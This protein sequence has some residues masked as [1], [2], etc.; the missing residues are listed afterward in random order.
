MARAIGADAF[1]WSH[2]IFFR[3]GAYRPDTR[4]GLALLAHE[5]THTLQQPAVAA[6][7]P[8]AGWSVSVPG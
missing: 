3:D 6:G 8:T 1:A 5:A 2:H 4:D 7:S